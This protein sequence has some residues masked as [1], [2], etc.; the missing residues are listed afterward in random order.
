M[1]DHTIV[2][3]I[4]IASKQWYDKLPKDLQEVIDRAGQKASADACSNGPHGFLGRAAR[5]L[6]GQ[7]RRH[8]QA[9]EGTSM[10]S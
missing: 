5:R 10:I 6:D 2:T 4:S 7:R 9:L 8:Q 3:V 1:T